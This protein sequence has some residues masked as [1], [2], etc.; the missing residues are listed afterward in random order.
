MAFR[1]VTTE[2]CSTSIPVSSAISIAIEESRF[3][4]ISQPPI[5]WAHGIPTGHE[6]AR[7]G[8]SPPYG[9][10]FRYAPVPRVGRAILSGVVPVA[11][12]TRAAAF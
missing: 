10:G 9:A 1:P 4:G 12:W 6:S 7:S 8:L 3:L 5:V 2:A 11:Q